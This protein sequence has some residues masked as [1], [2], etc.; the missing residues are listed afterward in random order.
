MRNLM[1]IP[2]GLLLKTYLVYANILVARDKKRA[3][4]NSIS[5]KKQPLTAV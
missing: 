2:V 3:L 4:R 5:E 1:T